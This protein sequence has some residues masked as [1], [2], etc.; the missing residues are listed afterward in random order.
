MIRVVLPLQGHPWV[1]MDG[2]ASDKPLDSAVLSRL[3]K[4]SAMNK[5]KKVAIRVSFCIDITGFN[6]SMVT[7]RSSIFIVSL[8]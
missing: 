7:I 1:R 6:L 8:D 2:V 5:L 3:K 4:F